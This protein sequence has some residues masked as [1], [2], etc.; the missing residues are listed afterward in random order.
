MAISNWPGFW[1]GIE[2]GNPIEKG[3]LAVFPLFLEPGSEPDYLI[4]EEAVRAAGDRDQKK[5]S[6]LWTWLR[7]GRTHPP[8]VASGREGPPETPSHRRIRAETSELK[9][10]LEEVGFADTRSER[11]L[12]LGEDLRAESIDF[13]A[14]AL[15]FEGSVLHAEL[16][17]LGTGNRP[18]RP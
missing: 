12:G 8:A 11:G 18:N 16:F 14:A 6:R 9:A 15:A 1:T 3:R 4:L 10:F 17:P 7:P 13:T 5:G 2:I